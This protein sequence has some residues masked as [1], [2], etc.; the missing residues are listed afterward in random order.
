MLCGKITSG[1]LV[2]HEQAPGYSALSRGC[3]YICTQISLIML[4]NAM[5]AQTSESFVNNRVVY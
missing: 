3:I 5:S 2:A 1:G 4:I